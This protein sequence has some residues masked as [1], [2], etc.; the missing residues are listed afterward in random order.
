MIEVIFK[1]DKETGE[2]IA[3]MPYE[4]CDWKGEFTCYAHIGQHSNCDYRYY[5]KCKSA[6]E[7]EYKE[8]LKELKYIGYD[9]I[10]IIK[11]INFKKFKKAYQD[12]LEKDRIFRSLT[13]FK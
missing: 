3:F 1:K 4:F 11:R 5:L 6:I 9:D 13:K 10:K 8:L 2:V 12:F 7:K